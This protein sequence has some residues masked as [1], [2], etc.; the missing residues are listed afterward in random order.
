MDR[1]GRGERMVA[2]EEENREKMDLEGG[3]E[4]E[5]K[6]EKVLVER[7]IRRWRKIGWAR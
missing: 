7:G 4:V 5:Q 6:M 2:R 3:M 1:V